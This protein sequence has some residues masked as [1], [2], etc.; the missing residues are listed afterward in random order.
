MHGREGLDGA[1]IVGVEVDVTVGSGDLGPPSCGDGC[2][3]EGVLVLEED[4]AEA[5]DRAFLLDVEEGVNIATACGAKDH[6][7]TVTAA[8]RPEQTNFRQSR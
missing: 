1:V 8:G 3:W 6:D 2:T 5:S 7:R 4:V